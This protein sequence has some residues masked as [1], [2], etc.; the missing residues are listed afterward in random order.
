[1][2]KLW[3]AVL[4][5]ASVSGCIRTQ[6]MPLAPNVVRLDTQASGLLFAGQSSTR[7][8]QRAAELTLQGGYTHFRF[9]QVQTA[10]GSRLAGVTTSGQTNETFSGTARTFGN[11]TYVNGNAYGTGTAVS[12]PIYAPTSSVGATVYMFHANEPGAVG[13]FDAQ[14]VLARIAN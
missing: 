10:Q 3:V 2:V 5:G 12:T 4:V 11:T 7:T 13:A 9:D 1:M 6:E 14:E 8:M